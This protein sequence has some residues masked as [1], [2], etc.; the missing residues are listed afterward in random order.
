MKAHTQRPGQSIRQWIGS[1][2]PH[3]ITGP[4]KTEAAELLENMFQAER[5]SGQHRPADG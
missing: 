1:K 2:H 4:L 5:Y 3:R